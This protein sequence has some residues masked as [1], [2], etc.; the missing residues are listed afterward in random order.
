MTQESDHLQQ[1]VLAVAR[2]DV[3]TLCEALTA[4]AL[5]HALKLDP[6]ITAG[7]VTLAPTDIFTLL[8][9]SAWQRGCCERGGFAA[10]RP[11]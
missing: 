5:L 10:R 8:F 11:S 2:K 1:P 4:Q 7:P 9:I 6:K 3:T